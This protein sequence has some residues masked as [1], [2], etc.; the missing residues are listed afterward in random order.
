MVT[1][2]DIP[3]LWAYSNNRR[4]FLIWSI[5]LAISTFAWSA[6]N[7]INS[8]HWSISDGIVH[9]YSESFS[10]W[11][12]TMIFFTETWK[13][14]ETV[15]MPNT[16]KIMKDHEKRLWR[17]KQKERL[18]KK[19]KLKD[20][21]SIMVSSPYLVLESESDTT[22]MAS[23]ARENGEKIVVDD[24]QKRTRIKYIQDSFR[25]FSEDRTLNR[26]MQTY[27]VWLVAGESRIQ[28]NIPSKAGAV[29]IFQLMPW[30]ITNERLNP[31]KWSMDWVRL[32]IQ[33][34]CTIA[35]RLFQEDWK[36]LRRYRS[37]IAKS[38]FDKDE[39]KAVE[40]ILFPLL[41]NSYNTG[42]PTVRKN[43]DDFLEKYPTIQSLKKNSLSITGYDIFWH[44]TR[45]WIA[46]KNAPTYRD[47]AA[48][49]FYK[50]LWMQR[51]LG[52]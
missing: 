51:A 35:L 26:L 31:E 29:W 11:K 44:F 27:I 21:G 10:S 41:I 15:K 52:T 20:S 23:Q 45:F 32:S 49:Y 33:K 25:N 16:W 34:Q 48:M 46:N 38:Y 14:L 4:C 42:Y 17:N 24:T 40:F 37:I 36:L 43:L 22:T 39:E 13:K 1:N 3:T 8:P 9:I 6:H 28:N 2:I 5:W 47:D 18:G 19:H 7:I 50:T 12:L 30:I